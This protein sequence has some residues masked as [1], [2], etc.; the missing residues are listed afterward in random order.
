MFKIIQI[1]RYRSEWRDMTT[2]LTVHVQKTTG[3]FSDAGCGRERPVT[4]IPWL[5]GT[6][7]YKMAQEKRK[8]RNVPITSEAVE[9]LPLCLLTHHFLI[10]PIRLLDVEPPFVSVV[11]V[12]VI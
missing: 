6:V 2:T 7:G 11:G 5:D 1:S 10:L 4:V 12:V 3:R 8:W 9:L